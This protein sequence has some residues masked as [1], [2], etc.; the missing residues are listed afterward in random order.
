MN[1]AKT[2]ITTILRKVVKTANRKES[3]KLFPILKQ[4]VVHHMRPSGDKDEIIFQQDNDQKH[5]TKS[6]GKY[7]E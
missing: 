2:K 4:I 3:W 6:V 1:V 7:I 5:T